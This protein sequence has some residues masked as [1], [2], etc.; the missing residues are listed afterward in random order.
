[1]GGLERTTTMAYPFIFE[2]IGL[3]FSDLQYVIADLST[4]F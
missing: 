3:F 1:M 2:N 4:R